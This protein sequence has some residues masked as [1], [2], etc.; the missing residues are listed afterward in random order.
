[1]ALGTR[2]DCLSP[3]VC[4]LLTTLS[5]ETFLWV[6]LGIQ[7]AHEKTLE[8]INRRHTL[9]EL[10]ALATKTYLVSNTPR[11][12]VEMKLEFFAIENLFDSTFTPEDDFGRKP[13]PASLHCIMQT[14]SLS[15][16][17]L[18][19]VGDLQQDILY[20]KGAGVKTVGV[21]N[22]YNSRDELSMAGADWIISGVAELLN[23][24]SLMWSR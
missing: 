7:S 5:R 1:M 10:H 6:E 22:Q 13:N 11:E 14:G 12:F 9:E 15:S 4:D 21:L 23:I 17:D 3:E 16:S 19:V 8:R 24:R 2:P 18:V 20:G